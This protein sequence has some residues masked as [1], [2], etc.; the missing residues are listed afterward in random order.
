[1][2]Q[3]NIH[4]SAET[5]DQWLKSPTG[6]VPGTSM[7]IRGVADPAARREL[8]AYLE[9]VTNERAAS[10]NR[11]ET[12]GGMMGGGGHGRMPNLKQQSPAQQVRAI[13][14]C[15]DAYFVTL[16]SDTEVIFWE[17]N[18][19]LKTDSSANGPPRGKPAILAAGM[20]GDRASIIFSGPEEISEFIKTEC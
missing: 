7:R 20:R 3:S 10:T 11:M 19:R 8:I 5:L 2:K 15:G 14:Y 13:R 17:F 9:V 16:G 18:L 12:R 4:W 1:M 6:L